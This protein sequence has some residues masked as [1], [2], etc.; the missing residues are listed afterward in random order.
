MMKVCPVCEEEFEPKT[1]SRVYCSDRCRDKRQRD[2]QEKGLKGAKV[3]LA[4][5]EKDECFCVVCKKLL[6]IGRLKTCSTSCR[7]TLAR[8]GAARWIGRDRALATAKTAKSAKSAKIAS[9]D[10]EDDAHGRVIKD[11]ETQDE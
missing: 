1:K 9:S 3:R 11:K 4:A 8:L 10:N 7:I 6:P 2:L 5:G